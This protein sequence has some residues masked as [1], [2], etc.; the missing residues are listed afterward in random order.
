M[1]TIILPLHSFVD[2]ITNSS[3]EV[4]VEP[5]EKTKDVIHEIV[6]VIL[7]K[8][9]FD[10]KSK[11]IIDV[12]FFVLRDVYDKQLDK[13]VEKKVYKGSKDYSEDT[14]QSV[15]I[16]VTVKP[17]YQNIKEITDLLIKLINTIEGVS[18]YC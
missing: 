10:L 16:E 11:D 14:C 12:Q 13:Y 6:D 15:Q 17:E 4:F 8:D 5:T 2:L 3:S 18:K 1:N 7:K 9:G